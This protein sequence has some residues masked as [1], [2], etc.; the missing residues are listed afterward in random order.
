MTRTRPV[1]LHLL[2]SLLLLAVCAGVALYLWYP[3][4]F[5]HLPASGRFSL[6]LIVS[7]AF[8]GPALTWLVNK[9]GKRGRALAFDLVII[10][11][12][13]L[14]A[15]AWGAYTLYLARPYFMV[16]AVDR[17]EVLARRDVTYPVTNPAFLDKPLTGPLIMY[18]HMPTDTE[19]YQRLLR[20]VMFEGKPDLPFRPEFWSVYAERQQLVLQVSRPLS[21]L[22]RTRPAAAGDIDALV[23]DNG[24]EIGGLQFVPGMIGNGHFTVVLDAKSGAIRGYLGTDPWT[25]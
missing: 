11:L 19:R 8:V 24:G 16:F 18:A 9:P 21:E 22:R 20:E 15:M 14:A 1:L 3:H 12:I 7:V 25:N 23:Q 4:P 13:Q 6:L 17:F 2:A 10:S 5:R